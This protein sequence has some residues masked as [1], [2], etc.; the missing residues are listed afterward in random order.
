MAGVFKAMIGV[1]VLCCVSTPLQVYAQ[2]ATP[3]ADSKYL[4]LVEAYA[5]GEIPHATDALDGWSD[6]ALEQAVLRALDARGVNR[7]AAVM[8]HTES[9]FAAVGS[10][11]SALHLKLAQMLLD[12]ISGNEAFKSRW[13][14]CVELL[15]NVLRSRQDGASKDIARL[16]GESDPD[17]RLRRR[18]DDPKSGAV[19]F[20][21]GLYQ[22]LQATNAEHNVRGQWLPH[23]RMSSDGRNIVFTGSL[24][25]LDNVLKDAIAA[26]QHAL[27]KEPDLL[28]AHLRLGWV[29]LLHHAAQPAREQLDQVVARA[30]E[31]YMLYLAHLFRGALEDGEHHPDAALQEYKAAYAVVPGEAAAVA[32]MRQEMLQGLPEQARQVAADLAKRT[33]VDHWA[34]PWHSFTH[35]VS[36]DAPI[37]ELRAEAR[38]P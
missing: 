27:T 22:E 35:G 25:L 4:Q 19:E 13:Q 2:A 21:A 10:M 14:A 31:P 12:R 15:K 30:T 28:D 7:K 32:L 17:T 11:R 23:N 6:A 38:T 29:L 18:Y 26:Y 34:D 3:S 20:A 24:P 33:S 36:D 16:L 5:R 1:L 37:E 8:L 9:A